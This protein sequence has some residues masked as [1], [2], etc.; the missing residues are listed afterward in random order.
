M[1]VKRRLSLVY[2][3]SASRRPKKDCGAAMAPTA[4]TAP[5]T[6]LPD[7]M[8]LSSILDPPPKGAGPKSS[9]SKGAL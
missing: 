1:S 2:A 7:N 4:I 9:A 6:F 3:G 5:A 8:T